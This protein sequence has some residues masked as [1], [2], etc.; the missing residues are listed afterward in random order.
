MYFLSLFFWTFLFL[1]RFD[2][3]ISSPIDDLN[4]DPLLFDSTQSSSPFFADDNDF[5][6]SD[7]ALP[8]ACS[9]AQNDL[10]FIPDETNLFSRRDNNNNNDDNQCLP[11]VKIG[12]EPLIGTEALQLFES[13]LD[14]LDNLV[15]PLKGQASDDQSQGGNTA[16]VGNNEED[17]LDEPVWRDYAGPVRVE[18]DDDSFCAEWTSA[19]G[20]YPIEL[21]CNGRFFGPNP[22][23]DL[24]TSI[25]LSVD[26]K[27][28]RNRNYAIAYD[29]L[30]RF[31]L[32]SSFASFASFSSFSSF[33]SSFFVFLFQNLS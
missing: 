19:W 28:E 25:V 6:T 22:I 26:A 4:L 3:S 8:N 16:P 18:P 11:P 15:L 5:L 23:T 27:T 1:T 13:P 29:C 21:C 24:D 12:T 20:N 2:F 33:S 7:A 14:S 30:C 31:S 17:N 9:A 10:S 32:F